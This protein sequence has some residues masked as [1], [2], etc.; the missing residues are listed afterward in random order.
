M[1]VGWAPTWAEAAAAGEVLPG[2]KSTLPCDA[3]L[4]L[5]TVP[6]SDDPNMAM[7]QLK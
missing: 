5:A 3:D 7:F 4:V 6:K 1:D 2:P